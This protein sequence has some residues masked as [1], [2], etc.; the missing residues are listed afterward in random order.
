MATKS[1]FSQE[2]WQML[3]DGPEWVLAAL[4]AAD[5]NTAITTK[6]KESKAFKNALKNYSSTS[7]VVKEVVADNAKPS[8]DVKG[9][10]LS[11]AEQ[12]LDEISGIL[13][14]KLTPKEA[15]QYREFLAS[16]AESVAEAAGEGVLGIGKK[17]SKKE[18]K[19][20][21]KIKEALKPTQAAQ[22][23]PS[24][25]FAKPKPA[26]K[27]KTKPEAKPVQKPRPVAKKPLSSGRPRPKPVVEREKKSDTVQ[28]VEF[29]G[30]HTV[31]AG[32]TLSHIALKFY[33]SAAKTKYM[34]IFEANKDVIGDN[35][36]I[37]KPGQVLKIPKLD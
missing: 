1:K 12:A 29:V 11:E 26:Q 19:A 24:S 21:A 15:N 28:K 33:N 14:S 31:A 2:E 22:A 7:S 35:P 25:I 6:A 20:L 37:I 10:T 5:G 27:P 18:E 32:E 16:V 3:T 8:K 9:A 17:I 34:A 23:K 30:E 4:A 36:N 13:D